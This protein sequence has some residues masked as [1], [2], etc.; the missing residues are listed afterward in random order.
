[1]KKLFIKLSALAL[2][3]PI[4]HLYTAQQPSIEQEIIETDNQLKNSLRKQLEL[5]RELEDI[6]CEIERNKKNMIHNIK[7]PLW[8]GLHIDNMLLASQQEEMH[9]KLKLLDEEIENIQK[10]IKNLKES[11]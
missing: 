10:N 11:L 9:Q 3:V 8:V 1:M 7:D 2:M 4:S 5:T 6:K